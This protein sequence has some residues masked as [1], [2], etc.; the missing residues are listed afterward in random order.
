MGGRKVPFYVVNALETAGGRVETGDF[1]KPHVVQDR[2][3]I[4]GQNPP[5]DHATA[6]AL[7]TA[8]AHY[9]RSAAAA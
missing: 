7:L 8:L 9:A 6:A 1:F 4:T 5:S 2:E 3:L